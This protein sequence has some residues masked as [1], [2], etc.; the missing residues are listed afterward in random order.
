[1]QVRTGG[2]LHEVAPTS[3][4][5]LPLQG[6]EQPG[7]HQAD[8][9]Q[10]DLGDRRLILREAGGELGTISERGAFAYRMTEASRRKSNWMHRGR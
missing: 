6:L 8:P 2:A 3:G 10:A 1:M 7:Q 5:I 4:E 9:F